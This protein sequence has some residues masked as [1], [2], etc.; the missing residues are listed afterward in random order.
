MI[1][2]QMAEEQLAKAQIATHE[3]NVA[4]LEK[5]LQDEKQKLKQIS[6][7]KATEKEIAVC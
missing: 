1:G 3:Q 6:G 5:S 2:K 7:S 4:V